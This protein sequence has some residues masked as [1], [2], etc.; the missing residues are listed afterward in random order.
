MTFICEGSMKA[1][2]CVIFDYA[3]VIL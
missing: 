1:F 3:A 2:E